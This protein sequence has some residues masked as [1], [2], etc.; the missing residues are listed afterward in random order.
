MLQLAF[1][2]FIITCASLFPRADRDNVSATPELRESL[3]WRSIWGVVEYG[4][5]RFLVLQK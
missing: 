2:M 4:S 3:Y 5:F 1:I